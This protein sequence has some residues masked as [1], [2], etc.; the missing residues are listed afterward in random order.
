VEGR[1]ATLPPEAA[2]DFYFSSTARPAAFLLGATLAVDPSHPLAGPLVETLVEQQRMLGA[3]W[4]TQDFGVATG[5]LVD[6]HRVLA[7]RRAEGRV[8]L[9]ARGR[10]VAQREATAAAGPGDPVPLTNLLEREGD[11]AVLRLRVASSAQAPVYF[12]VNVTELPQ[13]RAVRPSETGIA[14]E[15]WYEDYDTGRPVTEVAAGALVR[16]RLRVT[17]PRERHMVVL[18]DALPA[19]LEAVDLS[20]RTTGLPPGVGAADSLS[21]GPLEERPDQPARAVWGYGRWEAGWWSPFEHRELR[22]D[23]VVWF[24]TVL[25]P[26][27]YTATYVARATTPG[28][29]VRPPAQAEEMY[30]R[31]VN[32]RSDGGTLV[33]Q[34]KGE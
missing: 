22:D 30:N 6:A 1:R 9:S 7:A 28:T 4:N 3:G 24:A 17:V 10:T 32:G 11:D 27:T 12:W 25:W 33:V 13:V 15:R 31:G 5:A 26:G 14:V 18:D 23:R 34:A 20:L 21:A 2:R 8:T 16:V 19:G 29:F